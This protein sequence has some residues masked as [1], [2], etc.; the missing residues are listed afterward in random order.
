[1]KPLA[2]SECSS[3]L[4]RKRVAG[5]QCS[6]ALCSAALCSATP[7][8]HPWACQ[9]T[10]SK[11]FTTLCFVD[12]SDS[13][14]CKNN[15]SI[16]RIWLHVSTAVWDEALHHSHLRV[17]VCVTRRDRQV[18]FRLLRCGLL[19]ARERDRE[20][21]GVC[22]FCLCLVKDEA[23][24]SGSGLG[25]SKQLFSGS[26]LPTPAAVHSP[27]LHHMADELRGVFTS[28]PWHLRRDR[29]SVV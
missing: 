15:V 26:H 2:K 24:P 13:L 12:V 17:C 25:L 28:Q 7:S 19:W 29:K 21:D 16:L 1:M 4:S 14:R 8:R 6:L 9:C 11:S 27:R 10:W 3:W 23:T 20:R 5:I 18:L 22:V